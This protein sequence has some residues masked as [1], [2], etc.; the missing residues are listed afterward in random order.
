VR[1]STRGAAAAEIGAGDSVLV[2]HEDPVAL[3][4]IARQIMEDV[5]EADGQPRLRI[6]LDY[7]EVLM[8]ADAGDAPPIVS[9]GD[10][11]LRT[12]RAEPHVEPGQ[13]WV[14]EAFRDALMQ[15]PSLWRTAP[16]RAPDGRECFNIKKTGRDEPDLW[17]R[18]FRLEF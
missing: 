7:G 9:G 6:I 10:T 1:Q 18:L 4:R 14:T 5:Y 16:L 2:V 15:K 8:Q 3:A 12:A 17:V 13:I 11:I